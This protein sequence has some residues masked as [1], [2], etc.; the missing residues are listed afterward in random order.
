MSTASP[1]EAIHSASALL[2]AKASVPQRIALSS[3]WS[4]VQQLML[5]RFTP[6][7]CDCA[8]ARTA[9]GPEQEGRFFNA[10]L[11]QRRAVQGTYLQAKRLGD[12]PASVGFEASLEQGMQEVE[13]GLGLCPLFWVVHKGNAG[14]CLYLLQALFLTLCRQGSGHH[15]RNTLTRL[16]KLNCMC[17]LLLRFDFFHIQTFQ[18]C[19][20]EYHK[21]DCREEPATSCLM[22]PRVIKLTKYRFPSVSAWFLTQTVH[23]RRLES[24]TWCH[25]R[26]EKAAEQVNNVHQA[27]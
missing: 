3:T 8:S 15:L 13:Y 20:L 19:S 10:N 17:P 23:A 12:L 25:K 16:F 22:I 6:Q 21:H 14:L 1:A 2:A 11:R 24:E 27:F 18:P 26:W 9:P 7:A 4:E 5:V